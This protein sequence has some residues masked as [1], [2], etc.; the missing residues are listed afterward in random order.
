MALPLL[1]SAADLGGAGRGAGQPFEVNFG[2]FFWTWLVFLVL[3]FL[4]EEVRLAPIIGV[5]GGAGEAAGGPDRGHRAPAGRGEAAGRAEQ[6]ALA[7]ARGQAQALLAE[8]KSQSEQERAAAVERTKAEQDELLARARREIAAERER[9]I[10][11]TPPRGGGPVAGRGV[12]AGRRA[13][14]QPMPT[15]SSSRATWPRWERSIEESRDRPELRRGAVR[16]L[17][18]DRSCRGV[19]RAASRR[20]RRPSLRRP[21]SRRC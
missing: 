5:G 12:Q 17:G 15:G 16:A 14:R 2:L 8:A 3:L 6:K 11:G 20:W 4:L 9:A 10:G 13:A 21:R 7:E 18:V 19:R 1:A